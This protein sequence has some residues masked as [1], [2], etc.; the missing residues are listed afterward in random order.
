MSTITTSLRVV[1]STTGM[2]F[3]AAHTRNADSNGFAVS[4][5]T[6]GTTEESVASDFS[7]P[8]DVELRLLSG[9]DVSVGAVTTVYPFRL[10][11]A[12][13]TMKLRLDVEGLREITTV[14]CGADTAGSLSGDYIELR[15]LGDGKVWAWFDVDNGSTPPTPTTERLIEVNIATGATANAV[16]TALAAALAADA[17][18]ASATAASAVV[19]VTDRYTGTRSAATAGTTGWATPTETQ[20]GAASPTVYLKSAG[21]SQVMVAVAPN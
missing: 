9:S 18:Y 10:S 19:T 21:S 14:T 8:R 1:H 5:I 13:D 4:E 6:V 17:G 16:A 20:A 11:G 15:E 12:N 7:S 3:N 2:A